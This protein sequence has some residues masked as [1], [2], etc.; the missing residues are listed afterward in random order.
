[1]NIAIR[2]LCAALAV[3]IIATSSVPVRGQSGTQNTGCNN[4]G[5]A[6]L[7]GGVLGALTGG[8]NNNRRGERAAIGAV[9]AAVACMVIDASSRQ[10]NSASVALQDYQSRNGG[11]QPTA[12]VLEGYRCEAPPS[13]SKGV[14]AVIRSTGQLVVPAGLQSRSRF[15]ENFELSVP[16]ETSP[17]RKSKPISVAGGG[18]FEQTFSIPISNELPQGI[19]HYKSS[20]VDG[21]NRTLG[22]QAGQFRVI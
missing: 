13:V 6:A 20:I 1:M 9:V 21:G 3:C 18:G 16:G 14:N 12:P 15:T 19:Y 10:T 17:I 2:P 8:G 7:V 4:A 11:Q 5:A 22:E